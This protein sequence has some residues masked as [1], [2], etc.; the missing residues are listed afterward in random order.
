MS[1][2]ISFVAFLALFLAMAEVQAWLHMC[3]FKNDDSGPAVK[4]LFL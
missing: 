2:N 3:A 1:K 4:M